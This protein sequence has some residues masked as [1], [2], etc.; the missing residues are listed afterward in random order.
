MIIC[1]S[2]SV[3]RKAAWEQIPSSIFPYMR[4]CGHSLIFLSFFTTKL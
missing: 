3:P 2:V 4:F 1:E